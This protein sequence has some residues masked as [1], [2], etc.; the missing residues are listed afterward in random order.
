M[1]QILASSQEKKNKGVIN[2][3]GSSFH[4]VSRSRAL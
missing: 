2:D 3:N 4:L 1:A